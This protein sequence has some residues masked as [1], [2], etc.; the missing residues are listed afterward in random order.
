MGV[1][2][3]AGPVGSLEPERSVKRQLR[4]SPGG[5]LGVM[6]G[7]WGPQTLAEAALGD[8]GG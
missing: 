5:G 6:A 7:R 8:Y 4:N 3:A 2:E 1:A